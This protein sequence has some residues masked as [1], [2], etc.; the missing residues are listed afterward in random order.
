MRNGPI[1]Y[2]CIIL[3]DQWMILQ[4]V[5]ASD[6]LCVV[7]GF[8]VRTSQ[9]CIFLFFVYSLFSILNSVQRSFFYDK[10]LSRISEILL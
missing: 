2:F 9:K 1:G 5:N 7:F 3:Y 6:L 8:R 4:T 10:F